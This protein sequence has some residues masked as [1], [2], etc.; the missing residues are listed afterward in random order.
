MRFNKKTN[1]GA[2]APASS[3]VRIHGQYVKSLEFDSPIAARWVLGSEE[4]ASVNIQVD[5]RAHAIP[6]DLSECVIEI[7]AVASNPSD[8]VYRFRIVYAGLFDLADVPPTSRAA[9]LNVSCPA[10]LFP[11]LRNIVGTMTHEAGVG[12]LWL[13]P[14]DWATLYLQNLPDPRAQR[15]ER[16][17]LATA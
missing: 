16:V 4:A 10:I 5:V 17:S 11:G 6:G 12:A 13:D 2:A 8:T 9:V 14:M 1:G 7:E 15:R 3:Q